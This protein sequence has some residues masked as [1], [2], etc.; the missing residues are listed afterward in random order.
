MDNSR[1]NKNKKVAAES[2]TSKVAW[3][4]KKAIA[5]EEQKSLLNQIQD[6]RTW[7]GMVDGM[8]DEQLKE[9]LKNRPKELKTAKIQ[10]RKQTK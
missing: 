1:K 9:Y 8:N 4:E 10:K 7:V 2:S 5:D 3:E 6:L